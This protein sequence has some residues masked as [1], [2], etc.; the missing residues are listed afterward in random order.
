MLQE[1]RAYLSFVLIFGTFL[2][3]LASIGS[4]YSLFYI[5]ITANV[6]MALFFGGL[7]F[8]AMIDRAEASNLR[9]AIIRIGVAAGAGAVAYFFFSTFGQG[10]LVDNLVLVWGEDNSTSKEYPIKVY[11][12]LG[13]FFFFWY[14]IAGFLHLAERAG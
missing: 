9:V 8:N 7:F 12:L 14:I 1:V 13:L 5:L 4:P 6:M 2:G 10:D 11:A 3:L